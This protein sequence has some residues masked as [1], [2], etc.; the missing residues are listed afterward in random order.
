MLT[1]THNT[2][3]ISVQLSTGLQKLATQPSDQLMVEALLPSMEK[4]NF[5]PYSSCQSLLYGICCEV[6]SK[7]HCGLWNLSRSTIGL[8]HSWG[9]NLEHLPQLLS[10]LSHYKVNTVKIEGNK[11]RKCPKLR[12]N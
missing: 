9:T 3:Q 5:A 6:G 10:P 2:G 11:L 12:K 8:P 7:K 4:S 1:K